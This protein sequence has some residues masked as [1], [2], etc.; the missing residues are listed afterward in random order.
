MYTYRKSSKAAAVDA[1]FFFVVYQSCFELILVSFLYVN[2]RLRG[3]TSYLVHAV[4]FSSVYIPAFVCLECLS[5]I[6]IW[7]CLTD[8]HSLVANRHACS[9]LMLWW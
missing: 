9:F 2:Q 5:L 1:L 8:E 7:V 6:S 3:L 4:A